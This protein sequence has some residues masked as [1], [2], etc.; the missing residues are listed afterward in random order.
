MKDPEVLTQRL[1]EHV[2]DDLCRAFADESGTLATLVLDQAYEDRLVSLI[3]RSDDGH[4]L[5]LDPAGAL[6]LASAVRR[7]VELKRR[8]DLPPVVVCVPALRLPLSR[9]L[10]R[11]DPRIHVLS[12]TELS[13]EIMLVPAG[14]VEQPR[15]SP[16]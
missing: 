12:F 2:K 15:S 10:R 16:V 3:R 9:M 1:R 4:V 6:A 13:P 5:G 8:E 11:Y 14:L 7:H